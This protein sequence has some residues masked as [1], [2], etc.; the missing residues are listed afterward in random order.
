MTTAWFPTVAEIIDEAAER[1]RIDPGTLTVYQQMSARRSINALITAWQ[2][3][4]AMLPYV[5]SLATVALT[6][7]IS[8][9]TLPTDC[10]DVLEMA[11]RRDGVDVPLTAMARDE[12]I[13]IPNKTVQG[14]PSRYWVEKLSTGP[15]AH[16]WLVPD[17][18]T[19][20][21]MVN[22]L[23]LATDIK[24]ADMSAAPDIARRWLDALFDE[25]A[26]RMYQKFGAQIKQDRNG[27]EYSAF[28]STF[29]KTVLKENAK[30]SYYE[31]SCADRER[32]DIHVGVRF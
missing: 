6:Q 30:T 5:H 13:E 18:S 21:L 3:V 27:K 7:G 20:V 11:F 31:A 16:L 1:A 22:Y 28:D 15:V 25:L 9:P 26:V 17:R 14:R 10:Y 24:A 19:D 12:Y 4:A 8:S 2:N 32:A 23:R 29:Y